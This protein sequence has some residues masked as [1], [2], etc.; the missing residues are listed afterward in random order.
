MTANPFK[1]LANDPKSV[2]KLSEWH[3][4][5]SKIWRMTANPF[6]NSANDTKS[7][8]KLIEW[9]QIPAQIRRMTQNPFKNSANDSKSFYNSAKLE[10]RPE[11]KIVRTSRVLRF[12]KKSKIGQKTNS[13]HFSIWAKNMISQ[14][15]GQIVPTPRGSILHHTKPS[16]KPYNQKKM[17]LGHI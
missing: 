16:Q 5:R 2:Q 13:L 7:L 11:S 6:K 17:I 1:N 14:K 8:Q 4:I 12:R 10:N 15:Y 3:Q 9:H